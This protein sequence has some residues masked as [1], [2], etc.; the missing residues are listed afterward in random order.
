MYIF[1]RTSIIGAVVLIILIQKDALQAQDRP[2]DQYIQTGLES[3]LALASRR[4]DYERSLEALREARGLFFPNVSFEASYI[5]AQGGRTIDFPVGDLFNPVYRT[6]NTLTNEQR[7]PT[8]LANVN[9]QFLPNNF[10]ETKIRIVQPIFNTDIYY[11]RRAKTS[12]ALSQSEKR[13]A[14]ENELIKE[15]KVGYYQYLQ[16]D[17][18]LNIY[19]ETRTLLSEILR[20]NTSLVA[21]DKAT[22]EVISSAKFELS[23]LDK[24][25]AQA[26]K[27]LQVAKAYFNFLLNRSLDA[28]I[29]KDTFAFEPTT[30][31]RLS[32]LQDQALEAR[33]ELDQLDYAI[34][35]NQ[36]NIKRTESYFFPQVNGVVDIGYQGFRYTFD[37]DQD[38]WL[39]QLSLSWNIFQGFQNEAR[40]AQVKIQ[41]QSLR[42]QQASLS[43]Q[44]QLQVEEAYYQHEAARAKVQAS[45]EGQQHAQDVF[46]LTQRKYQEN[47]ASYLELTD[48]RTKLTQA[49][50]ER[51]VDTYAFLAQSAQLAYATG[52]IP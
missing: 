29:E 4:L 46:R 6:L 21:N 16:A 50:I 12:L 15:I 18:V 49:R 19:R 34:E 25:E 26:Q 20:V 48:A 31:E 28:P 36:Y 14:Y 38:F 8:D 10:H 13:K 32:V 22:P 1:K 33:N 9:E 7:F 11:N 39:A 47:Q 27:N 51:A 52:L 17:E 44:I 30:L 37:S 3:N 42:N 40:V 24:D 5:W 45:T 35:A 41:D 2:L 23:K 43:Q